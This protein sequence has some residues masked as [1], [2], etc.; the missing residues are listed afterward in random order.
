MGNAFTTRRTHARRPPICISQM[1]KGEHQ[2]G[3]P[4]WEWVL[5]STL[6]NIPEPPFHP[7]TTRNLIYHVY[8]FQKNNEWIRNLEQLRRRLPL[9]NGERV[10]AIAT[11]PGLENPNTVEKVLG[12]NVEYLI[13]P[14][15][16]RLR[17]VQTFLPLLQSIRSVNDHD[18]TFYAHTKGCSDHHHRASGTQLAIRYWRNRMYAELLDSWTVIAGW[19][20]TYAT[21]GC[22]KINLTLQPSTFMCS[23]TGLTSGHWHFAGTFFWIR[24]DRIFRDPH[25]S[26]IADDPFA[27]EMWLGNLLHF[28]EAKS[29]YQ[30]WPEHQHPHPCLY[31][32]NAHENPIEA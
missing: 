31:D 10:I 18:A 25:W 12:K 2:P 13:C 26:E 16:P 27:A 4:A 24:H 6:P 3:D 15:D 5:R 30:P 7:I 32:P 21:V 9:F 22:F 8:P 19:L 14:N 11:G 17:E 20:E 1:Y 29:V 28:C 23:P